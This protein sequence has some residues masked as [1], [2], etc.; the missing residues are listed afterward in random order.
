V[1]EELAEEGDARRHRRIVPIVRAELR[2]GDQAH[3]TFVQRILR[4]HQP[5]GNPQLDERGLDLGRCLGERREMEHA[6]EAIGP[7]R[8]LWRV[9]VLRDGV[10]RKQGGAGRAGGNAGKK[11]SPAH[12]LHLA[13]S[14]IVWAHECSPRDPEASP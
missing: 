2:I 5:T 11:P 1:V 7:G 8:N 4:V 13:E 10:K 14:F 12:A 6:T 9:E 3:R